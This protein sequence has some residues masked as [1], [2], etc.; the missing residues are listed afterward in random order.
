MIRFR[1]DGGP[2]YTLCDVCMD[3][4]YLQAIKDAGRA[5]VEEDIFSHDP[6]DFCGDTDLDEADRRYKNGLR[7]R[8]KTGQD[9]V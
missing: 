3:W 8:N 7:Q 2:R 5:V 1:V 6:C 4:S 9:T